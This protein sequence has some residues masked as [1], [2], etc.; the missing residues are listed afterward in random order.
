MNTLQNFYPEI[1][2]WKV[3]DSLLTI[4]LVT[5]VS[6]MTTN[7]IISMKSCYNKENTSIEMITLQ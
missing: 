3:G 2:T 1:I 6:R 5:S 4:V 7:L